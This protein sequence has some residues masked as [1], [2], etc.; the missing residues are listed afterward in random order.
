MDEDLILKIRLDTLRQN[1]S[2]I[3]EKLERLKDE[4]EDIKKLNKLINEFYIFEEPLRNLMK[5][6]GAA[7]SLVSNCDLFPGKGCPYQ[8]D[9]HKTQVLL[10]TVNDE[11][12]KLKEIYDNSLT[13]LDS[14]KEVLVRMHGRSLGSSIDPEMR[15]KVKTLIKQLDR[16]DRDVQNTGSTDDFRDLWRRVDELDQE[17]QE[18]F[19]EYVDLLHGL[20]MRDTGFDHGM[21]Q[22]A[23]NLIQDILEYAPSAYQCFTIPSYREAM[24][25][26]LANIIRLGFPEW[27]VWALPLVACDLGYI[28]SS[29][30]DLHIVQESVKETLQVEL[31]QE[32]V[33]ILKSWIPDAFATY[34][35][36]PAYACATMLLRFNPT[37]INTKQKHYSFFT[38]AEQ[39]ELPTDAVRCQ[40][41]L[42]M[43]ER[44]NKEAKRSS[45]NSEPYIDFIEKL[46]D[47]WD[48]SLKQAQPQLSDNQEALIQID[49]KQ[50]TEVL[51][52]LFESKAYTRY[53]ATDWLEIRDKCK[54]SEEF[55]NNKIPNSQAIPIKIKSQL[56]YVINAAWLARLKYSDREPDEIAN[57]A[58]KFWE[59]KAPQEPEKV[60]PRKR[61]T[62]R[63]L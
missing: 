43:L 53:S 22:L 3:E 18:V 28:I 33:L 9:V 16:I 1:L 62:R 55:S 52:D 27:T 36:G 56:R 60:S 58:I 48:V 30:I 46:K 5:I 13:E 8:A 12:R 6:T 20:A 51:W 44:M 14:I 54:W 49:V 41:I 50:W 21:C 40:V 57:T 17:S 29:S 42:C 24:A 10:E 31:N 2:Q 7:S 34:A 19:S 63:N 61:P 15:K 37:R 38:H 35:M 26:T 11:Y 45:L 32:Q 59:E 25:K 23:D 39:Q 47:A 4:K